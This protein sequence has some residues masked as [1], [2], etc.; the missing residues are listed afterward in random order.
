MTKKK[1]KALTAFVALLRGI[2]VGGH[3]KVPMP[4]LKGL[5]EKNGYSHVRTL[6]NSGNVLFE[7][8]DQ[9]EAQLE[10]EISLL[11]ENHFGFPIP[12]LIRR[13][14]DIAKV[15]EDNPFAHIPMHKGIRRYVTFIRGPVEVEHASIEGGDSFQILQKKDRMVFSVLDVSKTQSTD[16]MKALDKTYTKDITTRNW[17]TLLKLIK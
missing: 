6:L 17:N 5:L 12:V 11:L 3:H 4:E 1:P 16:L 14:S 15:I 8:E 2:N 10:K 13:R 7:E 9:E